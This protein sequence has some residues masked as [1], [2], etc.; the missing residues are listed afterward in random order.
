MSSLVYAYRLIMWTRCNFALKCECKE[1]YVYVWIA[2]Y[3]QI[4]HH[5]AFLKQT[6]NLVF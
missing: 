5:Q 3:F 1:K 6:S 4:L 2:E